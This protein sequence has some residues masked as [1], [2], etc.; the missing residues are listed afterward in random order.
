[1]TSPHSTSKSNKLGEPEAYEIGHVPFLGTTIWLDSRPLI[2]RTETE[3]WVEECITAMPQGAELRVLDLFAG[4]GC[5]GV[6]VL[7]QVPNAI[8][9]FG[10]LEER[11]IPTI[12]K[13]IRMNGIDSARARVIPTDVWSNIQGQYHYVLGNP[14]Y[15]SRARLGRVEE[16]V[17]EHE[18]EE[19]LFAEDDGFDL[20]RRT[21]EGAPDHLRPRGELWVEH[22]PEHKP[23]ILEYAARLSLEANTRR[24]QYGQE[25]YS[26]ILK[27]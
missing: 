12:E 4:S 6:A 9:D 27:P 21:L 2:P 14:P 24:D 17:L 5:V 16:S 13:N 10:E 8:V 15:L 7:K 22:E 20:V 26:V 11:H 23:R 25:R 19:A 3:W 1:M 18:P